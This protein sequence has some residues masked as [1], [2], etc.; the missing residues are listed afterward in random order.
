MV[1]RLAGAAE[2]RVEDRQHLHGDEG[3][4]LHEEPSVVE[5]LGLRELVLPTPHPAPL[6]VGVVRREVVEAGR[7]RNVPALGEGE[8]ESQ[9]VDHRDELVGVADA[10]TLGERLAMRGEAVLEASAVARPAC[11]I[12]GDHPSSV[13]NSRPSRKRRPPCPKSADS[14]I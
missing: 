5:A 7:D 4:L 10:V 12:L 8:A 13:T 3:G 11:A 6:A 1:V 14:S 2:R 9:L